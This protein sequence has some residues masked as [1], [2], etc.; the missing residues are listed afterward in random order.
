MD[1]LPRLYVLLLK[2]G[3]P[4]IREAVGEMMA[5]SIQ[6][7]AESVA[8]LLK[9]QDETPLHAK[10]SPDFTSYHLL[11]HDEQ[12]YKRPTARS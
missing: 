10:W 2:T 9:S 4:R 8:I 3:C 12:E 11:Y 6:V 1:R 5:V 7:H